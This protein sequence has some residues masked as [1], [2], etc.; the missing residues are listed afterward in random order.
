MVYLVRR[1]ILKE[2]GSRTVALPPIWLHAHG[3]AKGDVVELIYDE[4]VTIRP[5]S[6]PLKH[7]LLEEAPE[8]TSS[9]CR[10]P[11]RR[12]RIVGPEPPAPA[13]EATPEATQG[14]AFDE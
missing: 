8:P 11:I 2:G 3:L 14:E 13:P 6:L 10:N 12:Q 1:K 9:A 4:H 7:E 5:V